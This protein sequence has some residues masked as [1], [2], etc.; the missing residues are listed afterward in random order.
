MATTNVSSGIPKINADLAEILQM[1]KRVLETVSSL[2][3]F[4][5]WNEKGPDIYVVGAGF[6][7]PCVATALTAARARVIA[8]EMNPEKLGKGRRG[9]IQG[10]HCLSIGDAASIPKLI[11]DLTPEQLEQLPSFVSIIANDS[12]Y[13]S[14]MRKSRTAEKLLDMQ[15]TEKFTFSQVNAEYNALPGSEKIMTEEVV[16]MN[17]YVIRI[18]QEAGVLIIKHQEV[19][20]EMVHQWLG[21]SKPVFIATGGSEAN[22]AKID[23]HIRDTDGFIEQFSKGSKK[24]EAMIERLSSQQQ[25]LENRRGQ[26]TV[27]FVGDGTNALY[28][29]KS[30]L[31]NVWPGLLR[32]L[33]ISPELNNDSDRVPKSLSKARASMEYESI[34]GYVSD[35]TLSKEEDTI[36]SLDVTEYFRSNVL[37]VKPDLVVH[38]RDEFMS[39]EACSV[40][41][42]MTT[43][44]NEKQPING[45]VR[46]RDVVPIFSTEIELRI[47]E[48]WTVTLDDDSEL[49]TK[50]QVLIDKSKHEPTTILANGDNRLCDRLAMLAASL[51]YKS[52]FV[53]VKPRKNLGE[54]YEQKKKA[55]EQGCRWQATPGIPV[56]EG[57]HCVNGKYQLELRR[58]DGEKQHLDNIDFIIRSSGNNRITPL[59]ERMKRSGYISEIFHSPFNTL[60]PNHY[61]LFGHFTIFPGGPY[62]EFDIESASICFTPSFGPRPMEPFRWYD[63]FLWVGK[64]AGLM[65]L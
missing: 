44:I 27:A 56:N 1:P 49:K 54:L 26:V 5:K 11:P 55:I 50:I 34:L 20:F 16:H 2:G 62:E 25:D 3:K 35:M 38:S 43:L 23:G 64:M 28:C 4:P 30:L 59:L 60:R 13:Q 42:F 6:F 61:A 9:S 17:Q 48:P 63:N 57:I 33:W 51:G 31:E 41:D 32:I 18:L 10:T 36:S 65:N 47:T 14:L 29:V 12:K 39:K 24:T 21:E 7:F 15:K 45:I 52:R 58:P 8:H 53:Q 37:K 19:T 46:C 22:L 40:R